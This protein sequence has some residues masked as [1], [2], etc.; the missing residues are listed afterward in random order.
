M[1]E[2]VFQWDQKLHVID[3][4]ST[5][6]GGESDLKKLVAHTGGTYKQVS[7]FGDVRFRC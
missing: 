5:A 7:S 3:F 4:K 1:Y 6:K 2:E